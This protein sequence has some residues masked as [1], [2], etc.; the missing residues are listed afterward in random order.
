MTLSPLTPSERLA[1][2][3]L[4]RTP[5]IGPVAFSHLL[6]RFGTAE[7]AINALPDLARRN[8]GRAQAF[9][10]AAAEA[11]L[12]RGTHLGA[13]LIFYG[14]AGYPRVLAA[15]EPPPPLIWVLGQTGL[16][17]K[18]LVA[19]VG[20]RTASLGAQ[21]FAQNLAHDLGQTGFGIVSGLARGIDGAAHMGSLS[22]GTIAV[23][24]GGI[25][26]IYPQ[27][28]QELYQKI[29][30]VGLIVSESPPGQK[31]QARD[32]PRRNRIISGLSR[33]VVVVEAEMR[34]GSLITARLAL[35]QGREVLAVPG[36]PLDP[37]CHGTN[38]LIRQ[39]AW[40]CEGQE[41]V[42]RALPARD[43]FG[44]PEKI[45]YAQA[46]CPPSLNEA[47]IEALGRVILSRLVPT[48]IHR[49]E[50]LRSLDSPPALGLAAIM[51][52]LIAGRVDL[53]PGGLITI[54]H[55]VLS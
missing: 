16:L 7:R 14:E 31:A 44:E 4:A 18:D 26:D 2:L 45:H 36:S 40:L 21:R 8:G 29:S 15:T 3:R 39:G 12:E 28:H 47:E 6:A 43:L 5:R 42:L 46:F 25:D 30:D 48:P 50:L 1:R 52:L 41:D 11:E 55:E 35:E 38:D 54:A 27:E 37:R 9:S 24:A 22:T 33:A 13:K 34:S 32:F 17:S 10:K 19:I 49:D 51:E 23:L 20:A 53:S